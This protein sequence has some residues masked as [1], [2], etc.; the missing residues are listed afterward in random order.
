VTF[1]LF[2]DP[3][4]RAQL[5]ALL[6]ELP[7]LARADGVTVAPAL[8]ELASALDRSKPLEPAARDTEVEVPQSAEMQRLLHP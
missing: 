6:R 5:R 4:A 2:L 7:R 3:P 8:Q 1:V